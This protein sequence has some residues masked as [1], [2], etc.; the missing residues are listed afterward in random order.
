[1]VPTR[2]KQGTQL[3]RLKE[4]MAIM[5]TLDTFVRLNTEQPLNWVSCLRVMALNLS[6]HNSQL[7]QDQQWPKLHQDQLHL[8]Q[9]SNLLL[10]PQDHSKSLL[11][12]QDHSKS[13][14]Q[15]QEP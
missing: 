4:S 9:L 13:L 3:V 14:L 12:P 10:Q 2:S 6:N 7:H 11:Q 15:P 1:M 5:T 8:L